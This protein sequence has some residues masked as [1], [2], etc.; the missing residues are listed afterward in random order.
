MKRKDNMMTG[1]VV[2]AVIGTAVGAIGT[3]LVTEQKIDV[4]KATKQVAKTAQNIV[5]QID[6]FMDR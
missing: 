4:K 2:G 1:A 5:E 3:M 6:Y